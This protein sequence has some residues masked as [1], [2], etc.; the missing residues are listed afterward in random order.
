MSGA[1]GNKLM[2]TLIFRVWNPDEKRFIISTDFDSLAEFFE[3]IQSQPGEIQQYTGLK[4]T[5]GKRVFDGDLIKGDNYGPYRVFWEDG[6]WCSCCYSDSEP[7][8]RYETIEVISN[9]YETT[10]YDGVQ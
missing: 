4:D 8:F 10:D 2:K 7:L 9:I 5:H 3:R 1:L 6:A